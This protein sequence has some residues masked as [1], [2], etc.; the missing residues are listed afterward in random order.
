M[1]RV[2]MESTSRDRQ[3]KNDVCVP[4]PGR[5]VVISRERCGR[6]ETLVDAAAIRPL[7]WLLAVL[8]MCVCVCVVA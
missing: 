7:I 1:L 3:L 4:T 2:V 6:V 5:R 8:Y